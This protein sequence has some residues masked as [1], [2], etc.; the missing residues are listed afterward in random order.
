MTDSPTRRELE[1]AVRA[2]IPSQFLTT[3]SVSSDASRKAL[4]GASGL[5]TAYAR[6][7]LRGR[8]RR[9]ARENRDHQ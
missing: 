6:G 9:R 7:F 2:L 1:K 8:K 3:K 5:L 4:A